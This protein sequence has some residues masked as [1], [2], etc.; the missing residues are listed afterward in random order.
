MIKKAFVVVF[1]VLVVWIGVVQVKRG[2]DSIDKAAEETAQAGSRYLQQ[3]EQVREDITASDQKR[4]IG[5]AIKMY[6][7]DHNRPPRSIEDLTN[8]GN[9]S[10][11]NTHDPFGQPYRFLL[12]QKQIVVTSAGRDRVIDTEDDLKFTY[13]VQ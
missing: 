10:G 11:G 13:A 6:M 3:A 4:A 9:L 1:L 2:L 12:Q 7:I 8:A 5:T